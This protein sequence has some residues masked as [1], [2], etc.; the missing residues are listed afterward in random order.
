MWKKIAI[1]GAIAAAALGTGTAALATST[2]ST[3]S[4]P[5][6]SASSAKHPGMGFARRALHG[7]WVTGKAGSST[8]V[9]HDLIK[10]DVSAVSGSSIT[11]TA[12]D[13]TAQTYVVN[14]ATKVRQRS[15]GKGAP[16]T[17]STVHVGDHVLV[18]GTGTTTLTATGIVDVKK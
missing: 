11:V 12:R 5:A 6:S 8:F 10:G 13:K 9:T 15:A 17:I 16:S 1:G 4:S 3:P 7:Q 2:G 18:V 14:S